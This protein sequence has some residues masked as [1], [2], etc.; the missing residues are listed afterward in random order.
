MNSSYCFSNAYICD[1][2]AIYM[3]EWLIIDIG[4]HIDLVIA[5]RIPQ[6]DLLVY[7]SIFKLLP[8][9]APEKRLEK[10]RIKMGDLWL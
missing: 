8:S 5:K 10:S 6:I 3:G 1:M 2:Y 4:K 7:I 9:Y